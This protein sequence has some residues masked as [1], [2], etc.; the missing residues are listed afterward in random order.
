[1]ATARACSDAEPDDRGAWLK[2]S[3]SAAGRATGESRENRVFAAL[4][5]PTR[6]QLLDRLHACD[7]QRLADLCRN[8]HM[9]RQAVMK[10]LEILEEADLVI[11]S[12]SSKKETICRINRLAL[13]RLYGTWVAKFNA[14][15]VGVDCY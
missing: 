13:N 1:M 11:V 9:S 7:N 15:R 3:D 2:L 5:D 10:H 4:A 12:R 6:R 14:V 8:F